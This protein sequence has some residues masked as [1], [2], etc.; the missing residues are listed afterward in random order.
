MFRRGRDNEAHPSALLA[1]LCVATFMSSLDVL[2]VN[3]GLRLIGRMTN[4]P[5]GN[6][7]SEI[8]ED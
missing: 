3:V 2:V 6:G 8:E 1:I 4:A 7:N 5:G